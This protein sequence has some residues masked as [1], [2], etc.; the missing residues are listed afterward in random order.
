MKKRA[1]TGLKGCLLTVLIFFAYLDA[2]AQE[3]ITFMPQWTPQTQFAGYYVAMAKGF[4]A[5]EGIEVVIDHFGGSSTGTAIEQMARGKVDIIT[6]QVVT[7][8]MARDK[9]LPLVNV[10]QTSQV[11]GLMCAAR[12]PIDSPQKLSGARIGRWKVGFGEVC[13]MFCTKNHLQVDWIPYIQGINLYVSGAVDALLCYSYS[14]FLQLALATGG[15]PQENVIWFR[16][17]GLNYPEDG[18]Y[19][20]EKYYKAHR[21]TVE[22][23]VRAS[24]K[25]WD[26]AREHETEAL[27]ISME[28]IHSFNVATSR[29][30]QDLMLKEILALQINPATGVADFAP[31]SPLVFEDIKAAMRETGALKSDIKYEDMIR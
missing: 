1:L 5:E 28:I 12:F 11:N 14:E 7:A 4:Y 24:R 18:L 9:G 2:S 22:K 21:E 23:F 26:Y 16:D 8:M 29:V 27:E 10:L 31:V 17:Y 15:V 25:G 19:V 6:S 13:D 3:V 20:T 30:L